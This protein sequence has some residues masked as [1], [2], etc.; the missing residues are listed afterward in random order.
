MGQTI[1]GKRYQSLTGCYQLIS[2]AENQLTRPAQS[3]LE[4]K[5][6]G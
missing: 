5:D 6:K 4:N 2:S 3:T 1:K